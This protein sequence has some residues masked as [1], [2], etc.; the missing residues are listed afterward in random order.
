MGDEI[1]VH[2]ESHAA[3]TPLLREKLTLISICVR[4]LHTK[5]QCA[6]SSHGISASTARHILVSQP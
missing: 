1:K 5:V 2:E 3:S 4:I 6:W